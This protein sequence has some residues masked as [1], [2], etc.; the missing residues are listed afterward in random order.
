MARTIAEHLVDTLASVGVRQIYGVVGD[1]QR[2][3]TT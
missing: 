1:P 2:S 3:G